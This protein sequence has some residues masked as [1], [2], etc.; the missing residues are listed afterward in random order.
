[1]AHGV[2][3][4]WIGYLLLA[5]WRRWL[6]NPRKILAPFVRPNTTSLDIGCGMGY[7]S[8]H[9][10]HMAGPGGRV[11][12]IDLQ[13][14]MIR[15]LQKRAARAGLAD[16]IDARECG[17]ANLGLVDLAGTVDFALAFAVV[18][19]APDAALFLRQIADALKPG[20]CLLLAEPSGHINAAE[21]DDTLQTASREGFSVQQKLFIRRSRSRLLE[22]P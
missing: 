3:P 8:L 20:G 13:E 1:M 18:H 16:R 17:P 19:E 6:Q 21:F 7:F 2:C 10:A 4:W 9:M 12:C 15:A 22:K 14:R 11:I 5:P